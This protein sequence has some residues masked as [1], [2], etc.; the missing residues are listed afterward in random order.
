MGQM[1]PT[2]AEPRAL[3]PW[4]AAVTSSYPP[5]AR[6]TTRQCTAPSQ[7]R[8]PRRSMAARAPMTSP[9]RLHTIPRTSEQA[10]R[11]GGGRR[12]GA[13]ATLVRLRLSSRSRRCSSTDPWR[14]SRFSDRGRPRALTVTQGPGLVNAKPSDPGRAR[15]QPRS[16]DVWH[17]GSA[18]CRSAAVAACSPK[19]GAGPC[20][21]KATQC[22]STLWLG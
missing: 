8:T 3:A 19:R 11:R 18:G 2:A 22:S 12:C 10:R 7:Q 20:G 17:P 5:F 13:R 4:S 6:R 15:D 16:G 1:A 9:R 21:K 14:S